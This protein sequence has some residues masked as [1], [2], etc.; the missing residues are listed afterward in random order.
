MRLGCCGSI[1]QAGM[2]KDA[3]FDFLE[4]AVGP[5]LMGQAE[6]AA[7]A[8]AAKAAAGSALPIEAANCLVPGSLPV[9]GPQRDVAALT[10]YMQRVAKRAGQ[11]GIQ[12]LVF[13]S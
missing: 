10:Q 6:D 11:V 5:V 12:R 1:E 3:G 7:W 13:G 2:L 4:V 9:V 8:D